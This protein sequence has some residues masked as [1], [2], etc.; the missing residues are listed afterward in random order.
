MFARKEILQR[1]RIVKRVVIVLY[2][3]LPRR[4]GACGEYRY[5]I[6]MHKMFIGITGL[7]RL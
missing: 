1:K 5:Q 2:T 7:F 4:E 6:R 3:P